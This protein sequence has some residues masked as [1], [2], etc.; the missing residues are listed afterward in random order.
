MKG[1]ILKN[2]FIKNIS[3]LMSGTALA[4]L[5]TVIASPLLSRMYTP[6]E[7]G[8]FAIYTSII[9]VLVIIM[10]WRYELAIVIPRKDEEAVNLV[11]LCMYLTIVM[12][13]S[14]LLILFIFGGMFSDIFNIPRE[15]L[16][17]IPPSIL[18][19]GFYSGLRYWSTRNKQF[20]RLSYSS[21]FRSLGANGVQIPAGIATLGA[22]GLIGGQTIGFTIATLVLGVQVWIDDKYKFIKYKSTKEMKKLA[23]TYNYFPKFSAPQG[24]INSFSQTM[25]TFFLAFYFGPQVAGFYALSLKFIQLPI[26]LLGESFRQVF[27]QKASEMK[28]KGISIYYTLIKYTITLIVISIIPVLT[29]LFFGPALY[30]FVLGSNWYEAGEY[31]QWL[32]I[33]IFFSFI[34]SPSVVLINVFQ[35]QRFHLVFE[36]IVLIFRVA[37]MILGGMFLSANY[38]VAIYSLISAFLNICLLLSILIIVRRKDINIKL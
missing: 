21:I 38:T 33:T 30:S 37:S 10:T 31:A 24:F 16:W 3:I 25:P 19:L 8:Y 22:Q 15:L 5:L 23:K 17:W 32:V 2:S 35:L 26:N 7:F 9:T 18:M 6:E 36:I 13:L 1:S 11:L 28:Q 4:Q 34:T 27:F 20:K 12:S 29:V 14:I